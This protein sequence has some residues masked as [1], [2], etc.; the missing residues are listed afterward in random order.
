MKYPRR[1][2]WRIVAVVGILILVF[3]THQRTLPLL[4][5]WLDVGGPPQ[6]ADAVVLLNGGFNTRPFV[7]AA[8]LHGGW[9]PKILLNTVAAYASQ[10]S[11]AV[12]PSFEIVLKVLDYGG[13]PQD[14]VVVLPS[15]AATTFDEAKAVADYLADPATAPAAKK[16]KKLLIV[17]EGPHTRRARWIFRRVLAGRPVEIEMISAPA[18]GF[19]YQNW[20]RSEAGFLFVVSEYFKLFYY[21]LRYGWLGYE[22]VL[23]VAVLIFLRAW[24]LRRRKQN[25]IVCMK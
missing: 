7:A 25:K 16:L 3:A 24:F 13:V 17:T 6:N 23:G 9:A 19:E 15:A 2:W 4:A 1:C 20:W 14:C 22:I 10:A 8:L 11:G 5:R 12:P 18:D 21:G